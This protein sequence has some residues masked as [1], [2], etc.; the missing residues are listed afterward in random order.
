MFLQQPTRYHK[1]EPDLS[2]E[3]LSKGICSRIT[4]LEYVFENIIVIIFMVVIF[5]ILIVVI[6]IATIII[7]IPFFGR[8]RLQCKSVHQRMSV[9]RRLVPGLADEEGQVVLRRCLGSSHLIGCRSHLAENVL[10]FRLTIL[11]AGTR[12]TPKYHKTKKNK[13]KK[14]E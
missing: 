9:E 8:G 13:I 10:L 4:G 5:I 14:K 11:W 12:D 7:I 6:I 1:R 2:T 3:S